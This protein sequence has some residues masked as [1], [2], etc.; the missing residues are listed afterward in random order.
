MIAVGDRIVHRRAQF[1]PPSRSWTAF[2]SI[3]IAVSRHSYRS[4]CL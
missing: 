1:R 2:I 3:A 4:S